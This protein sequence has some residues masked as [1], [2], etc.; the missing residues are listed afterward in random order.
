M[1]TDPRVHKCCVLYKMPLSTTNLV[2]VN[3]T[4]LR[5]LKNGRMVDVLTLTAS[6]P[7]DIGDDSLVMGRCK[8]C[9]RN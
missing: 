1:N 7:P 6:G 8:A 4:K 5:V 2:E 9:R 3:A